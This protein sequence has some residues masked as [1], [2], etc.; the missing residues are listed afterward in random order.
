MC[1]HIYYRRKVVYCSNKNPPSLYLTF[2]VLTKGIRTLFFFII[3][4]KSRREGMEKKLFVFCVFGGW[5]E[6]MWCQNTRK[7]CFSGKNSWRKHFHI[8]FEFFVDK[9]MQLLPFGYKAINPFRKTENSSTNPHEKLVTYQQTHPAKVFIHFL[10]YPGWFHEW[11]MSRKQRLHFG[12]PRW[13]SLTF[14]TYATH[15]HNSLIY[16]L[17]Y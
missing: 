7:N 15:P 13:G 6:V 2:F 9:D 11:L 5:C 8:S 4:V 14:Q 3:T 12:R 17:K 1:A 10:P 16:M